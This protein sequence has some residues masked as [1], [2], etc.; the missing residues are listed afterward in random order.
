VFWCRFQ[1]LIIRNA[2]RDLILDGAQRAT[3]SPWKGGWYDTST[4]N[5]SP[6]IS[7][8]SYNQNHFFPPCALKAH[9]SRFLGEHVI[10]FC[11]HETEPNSKNNTRFQSIAKRSNCISYMLFKHFKR[12]A[13]FKQ[14]AIYTETRR[15]KPKLGDIQMMEAFVS[16]SLVGQFGWK[17]WKSRFYIDFIL[18]NCR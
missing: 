12:I 2:M 4:P 7:N 9:P 14:R 11:H 18:I 10:Q 13:G 17:M 1:A 6:K 5:Y 15:R 16:K 3:S 8:S